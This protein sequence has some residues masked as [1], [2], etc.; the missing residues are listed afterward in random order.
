MTF[1]EMESVLGD[2][3]VTAIQGG[4]AS[5][6]QASDG[7]HHTVATL[8]EFLV[9]MLAAIV[10]TKTYL[11]Q[12]QQ[13]AATDAAQLKAL[14]ARIREIER[15]Q[16]FVTPAPHGSSAVADTTASPNVIPFRR[17]PGQPRPE[18]E[19]TMGFEVMSHDTSLRAARSA[20]ARKKKLTAQR[21][22][23]LARSLALLA[24]SWS[25]KTSLQA[26]RLGRRS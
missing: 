4:I 17:G 26:V 24:Q 7:D 14:V 23:V 22:E 21:R 1:E 13:L 12:A 15:H 25:L 6:L 10:T 11:P 5:A 20:I 3:T 18:A 9:S 2:E 16:P 19:P 8:R